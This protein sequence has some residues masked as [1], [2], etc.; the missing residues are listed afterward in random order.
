MSTLMIQKR[1]ITLITLFIIVS[2]FQNVTSVKKQLVGS[3]VFD[4]FDFP[5]HISP[6]SEQAREANKTNKGLVI[7]FT[8]DNKFISSQPGGIKANNVQTVYSLLKDGT[9]LVI[10]KPSKTNDP[11]EIDKIDAFHL[12]LYSEGRPTLYFIRKTK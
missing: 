6:D 11:V 1:F 12:V 10:G 2:S 7:T 5:N 3:W 8:T 4:K 9:Y